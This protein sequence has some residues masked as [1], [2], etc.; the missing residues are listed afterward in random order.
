MLLYFYCCA[1]A[2]FVQ[3]HVLTLPIQFPNDYQVEKFDL[4]TSIISFIVVKH[5]S[6]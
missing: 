5:T 4:N 6:M 2:K 1:I 3:K